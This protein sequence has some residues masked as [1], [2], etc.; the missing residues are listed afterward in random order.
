MKEDDKIGKKRKE[1]EREGK[2]EK[3]RKRQ[4]ER[5]KRNKRKL[6]SK[7]EANHGNDKLTIMWTMCVSA[8]I[9]K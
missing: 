9:M 3:E 8:R 5:E 4:S 1:K 6:N 2:I 7:L